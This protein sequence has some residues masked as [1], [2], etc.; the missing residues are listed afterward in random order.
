MKAARKAA[1]P[2]RLDLVVVAAPNRAQVPLG[3]AA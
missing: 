1:Y 2:A 3:L